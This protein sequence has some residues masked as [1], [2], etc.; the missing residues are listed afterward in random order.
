VRLIPVDDRFRLD[1]G[2]LR[3]A[4]QTDLDSCFKPFCIVGSAGT[5]NTG[6]V[7]PLNE[8]ANVAEEFGLWFHVDGAY[9][10]LA[11]LDKSKQGLFEGI[12]RADSISLDPHKWLYTPLDCGCL[13]FRDERLAR[14][15]FSANEA[16]YIKVHEQEPNE[17]FAFWDYGIELSRRFRALKIWMTL[18]YY[19]T[20]RI[21]AAIADDN[22]LAQYLGE[23]VNGADDFELLA[24]VELSICCFRY[25]PAR[26][27]E[28]R[29]SN[30]AALD[31]FN[32]RLMHA[33]QR[34]GDAYLSNATVNGKFALRICITNFRTSRAD[35]DTTLEVIRKT[36][37]E[38]QSN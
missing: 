12:E 30:G 21:A 24:Q 3:K 16:D 6:A 5:V 35:I 18:R 37:A 28:S 29:N 34:G 22:L 32:T 1:V 2:A 19:G 10:A 4:I 20:R 9:G 26:L 7:D 31:D 33:I 23:Q 27:R 15:A 8:I 17:S 14:K 13:L 25:L 11:A 36:A 38:L